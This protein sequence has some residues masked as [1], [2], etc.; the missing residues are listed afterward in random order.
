MLAAKKTCRQ[1]P[2]G[3]GVDYPKGADESFGALD[4]PYGIKVLGGRLTKE[5][6]SER[7]D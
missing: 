6:V 3:A 7:H 2:R 5:S 4:M 1:T